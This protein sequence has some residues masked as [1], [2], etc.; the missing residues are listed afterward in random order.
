[1]NTL[2]DTATARLIEEAERMARG[3]IDGFAQGQK[4]IGIRYM[5][6]VSGMWQVAIYTIDPNSAAYAAIER[7]YNA[8]DLAHNR[9]YEAK[10]ERNA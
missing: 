7:A 9:F 4:N 5:E 8:A 10:R 1:M 6:G 2:N 3:A